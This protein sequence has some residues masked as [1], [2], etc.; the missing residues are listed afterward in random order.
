[1][2]RRKVP[3]SAK[4]NDIEPTTRPSPRSAE[5]R[6]LGEQV[7]ALALTR[8]TQGGRLNVRQKEELRR[9]L[10]EAGTALLW[11]EM[12]LRGAEP[13][14]KI[15]DDLAKLTKSGIRVIEREV[16]D[17]LKAK[18]TELKKLQKTVDQA[19]KLAD[20]KDPKLPTE[21]TYVHTARAAAQGLV[22]KVET[23]EV[24]SKD[25]ANSCAD[26]I[27]KSLGRWENLRDQ[28]V[29]ELK[30]KE[31]Q[32]SILGEQVTDFV[33]AQRSMIKEVVAILH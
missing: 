21:I 14:D 10:I 4:V 3:I 17:E 24:T 23:V 26:S 7:A 13:F 20:S 6:R 28:M 5:Y 18:K 11:N 32:L 8:T 2:Q 25:E 12:A 22:T 1:M 27:E 9:A 33:Q 19:R 16:Q 29:D 15:A 31:A 30:K